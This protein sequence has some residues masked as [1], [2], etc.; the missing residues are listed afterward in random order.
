MGYAENET[1]FDELSKKGQSRFHELNKLYDI[2]NDYDGIN[3]IKTINDNA[4]VKPI[5]VRQEII[6]LLIF[7]KEWYSKTNGTVNIAL[8]PMLSIWHQYRE[9]GISNPASARIPD[10]ELLKI[11]ALKT[12]IAK[13]EID[14]SNKTVFLS[15]PG[16]SLDVG[17]VAKGFA[18]EIVAME[19]YNSGFTSF[20]IDSGGNVRTVGKPLDGTRN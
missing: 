20:I 8:G 19:L 4:G 15:Q 2:Y 6:D 1:Q 5:A 18:T 17:A 16:M 9:E 3:N 10:I 13:V 14:P 11:A 7:S 12:D